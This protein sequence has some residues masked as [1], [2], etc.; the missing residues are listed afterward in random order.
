MG[1]EADNGRPVRKRARAVRYGEEGSDELGTVGVGVA[2]Y[3][4]HKFRGKLRMY[5]GTAEEMI[6]QKDRT[7]HETMAAI[8]HWEDQEEG[9]EEKVL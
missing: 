3:D 7:G 9:D 5:V 8:M 2:V 4:P 6:V 1:R